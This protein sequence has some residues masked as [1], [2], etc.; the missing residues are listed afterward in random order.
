MSRIMTSTYKNL[1]LEKNMY[2]LKKTSHIGPYICFAFLHRY[3]K[4]YKFRKYWPFK[5]AKW[6]RSSLKGSPCVHYNLALSYLPSL[7]SVS[8]QSYPA[9]WRHQAG[10]AS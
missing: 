10:R 3:K 5:N 1:Y 7:S 9:I 6:V 8:L 2:F 4:F